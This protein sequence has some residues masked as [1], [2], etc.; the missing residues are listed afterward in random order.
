MAAVSARG[1][2]GLLMLAVV[3]ACGDR[4]R[5]VPAHAA[6]AA[7]PAATAVT[8]ASTAAASS[9]A[10]VVPSS[11]DRVA[12][13][14]VPPVQRDGVRY[15]Q[16]PDGR[17]VGA[18]QVGGVLVATAA[19]TGRRLWTMVVYDEKI[20]PAQEADVQWVFFRSMAFDPDGRLR[21]VNEAGKAFLVDV[22]QRTVKPA[23]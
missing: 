20:S 12:P 10:A 19:D 15:S 17:D 23:G 11:A 8:A 1:V 6:S 5:P 22:K 9:A 13:P 2:A 14:E 16:A 4:D 7:V 21:I 3:T 18:N